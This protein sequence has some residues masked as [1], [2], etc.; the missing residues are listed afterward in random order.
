LVIATASNRVLIF[1]NDA[2][3]LFNE[4]GWNDI[5][6]PITKCKYYDSVSWLIKFKN[7]IEYFIFRLEQI[8]IKK[9][10]FQTIHHR[11]NPIELYG[12]PFVGKMFY[13]A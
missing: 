8:I 7:K 6:E 2:N 9:K 3:E 13:S 5:F 11:V 12:C 1:Q 10:N 4:N